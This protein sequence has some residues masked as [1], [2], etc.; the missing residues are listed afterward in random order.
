MSPPPEQP[1]RAFGLARTT[2]LAAV[3]A[4]AGCRAPE[5]TSFASV[6]TGMSED[7]VVALLGA[8][9]SRLHPPEDDTDR[10][11]RERWHWGD[12]LG[13][14]ATNAAMPDQPPPPRLW[15]VWFDADGRVL[16]VES[17]HEQHT[18]VHDT[19]WLP[20]TIPPR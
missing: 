13:T 2:L 14:L 10:L 19:P 5:S 12:T 8:P 4:L 1:G 3:G 9:S 16:R 6:A 17:P 7:E 15:T 11:W 18:G 20:P